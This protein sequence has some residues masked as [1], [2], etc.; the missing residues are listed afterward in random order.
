MPLAPILE[1]LYDLRRDNSSGYEKPYKPALLLSILDLIEQGHFREND[2]PLTDELIQRYKTLIGIVGRTQ[3]TPDKI[4]YPYYHLS[5]E[6][7]W[8]LISRHLPKVPAFLKAI[9]P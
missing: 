7:F 6:G 1:K 5:G 8:E 9:Q 4:Q 2:F 3:D